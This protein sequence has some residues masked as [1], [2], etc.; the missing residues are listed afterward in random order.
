MLLVPEIGSPFRV[1]AEE[2][3]EA[4]EDVDEELSLSNESRD[5]RRTPY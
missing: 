5:I 4:E 1:F 3:A 2:N